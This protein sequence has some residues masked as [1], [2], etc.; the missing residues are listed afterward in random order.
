MNQLN[1][2]FVPAALAL[3]VPLM[4]SDLQ[5][6]SARVEGA[7]PV[8]LVEIDFIRVTKRAFKL[9]LLSQDLGYT[10]T[11]AADG[12]VTDCALSRSFRNPLTTR[13]MCR[14]ITRAVRLAPALDAAGNA[15]SGTYQGMI[16]IQSPF[17]A[18]Q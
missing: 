14:S 10:L 2:V 6:V 3:S 18:S 12:S 9:G 7:R 16:R 13:E 17:A 5:P 11:V 4:A 8:E 15:V 1:R